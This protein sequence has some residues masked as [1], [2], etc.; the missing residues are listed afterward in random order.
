V[1]GEQDRNKEV[2][3]AAFAALSNGDAD[4]YA[5]AH[6]PNGLNHAPG[7]FD[8]SA[9]PADGKPFGPAE[10]RETFEWLRGGSPDLR[11]EV[12]DL[13]A[14]GDQVV[15]WVRMTGSQTGS[16]GPIPPTGRAFDFHHAHRF[17]LRNGRIVEH[18][19]V[20]DDLRAMIQTGVVTPPGRPDQPPP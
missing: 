8:L 11:V 5:N 13:V 20:R 18:W 4:A 2:V 1:A 17:R 3:R 19:A 10:A 16:M 14:E 15:A 9:W 12:E 6:D 7:P